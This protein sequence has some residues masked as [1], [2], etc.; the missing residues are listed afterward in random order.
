MR[1]GS[2]RLHTARGSAFD[3]RQVHLLF[4]VN[5]HSHFHTKGLFDLHSKPTVH[6]AI[7]DGTLFVL[8]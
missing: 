4:V 7:M 6:P 3:I 8:A 5:F 2:T 1:E